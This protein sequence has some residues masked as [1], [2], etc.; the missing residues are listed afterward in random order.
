MKKFIKFICNPTFYI[1]I[2]LLLIALLLSIFWKNNEYCANAITEI[3]G[4]VI[5]LAFVDVLLKRKNKQYQKEKKKKEL[6]RLH[7]IFNIYV[8]QYKGA[9]ERIFGKEELQYSDMSKL[10]KIS[11]TRLMTSLEPAFHD[12]FRLWLSMFHQAEEYLSKLDLGEDD[13]IIDLLSV[14]IGNNII[15]ETLF[16]SFKQ[17]EK[18]FINNKELFDLDIKMLE[19]SKEKFKITE[20]PNAQD[21]YA[22]TFDILTYNYH[23]IK[24]Y[25]DL[26]NEL[27][28]YNKK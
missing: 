1:S 16:E 13:D 23:F 26:I 12:F 3:I 7:N 24:N 18:M 17:R 10:L 21:L 14:F 19:E 22:V 5:T 28:N 11:P 20:I 25:T 4:I 6:L 15:A 27:K 9:C 8:M 2:V